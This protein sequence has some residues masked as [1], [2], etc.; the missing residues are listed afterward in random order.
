MYFKT[1]ALTFLLATANTIEDVSSF[2]IPSGQRSSSFVSSRPVYHKASSSSG[3]SNTLSMF[4]GGGAE[5][6]KE[7]MEEGD[8]LSK[9]VRGA[10]GLF[11]AGGLAAV[12]AAAALGAIVTPPGIAITVAASAITGAAGLIGKNRIDVA[13]AEA[14]K[15]AI[16]KIIVDSGLD[17]PDVKSQIDALQEKFGV[18]DED[19]AAMKCDVYKKYIIGMVKTPITQTSELKELTSLKEVLGLNN[20]S[21]GEAHG[22]AAKDF[23][24]QTCRFTPVEELDDPGHPDR[25]SIDKFLFLSERAFRQGEETSEAFKYEMSRVSKAFD[26]KLDEALERVAE[27]AEPF[28]QTAL[29]SARSKIN[30]DAVSSEMLTRAR[31]SLGINVNTAND[32]HLVTFADEVKSLLGKS[33]DM[34]ADV[35]LSALKFADGAKEKVRFSFLSSKLIP[36]FDL[37]HY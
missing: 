4:G 30:S 32:M 37:F 16:A 8:K 20:V 14:A 25:M 19:F 29:D 6:L 10:P 26:I 2:G 27:V 12:P 11:K 35:D 5:E 22:A 17:A 33:D 7:V 31:H 18:E 23:Y 13:S 21:V 36:N 9:T 15:P 3:R 1:G 28:Y 24:S 34:A